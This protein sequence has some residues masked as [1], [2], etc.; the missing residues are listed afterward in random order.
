MKTIRFLTLLAAVIAVVLVL[1]LNSCSKK[2]DNGPLIITS[3]ATEITATSAKVGGVVNKFSF[4]RSVYYGTTSSCSNLGGEAP[5]GNGAFEITLTGLTPATKYYF[6]A[7]TSVSTNGNSQR[8]YGE[9]KSFTT[10]ARG[11]D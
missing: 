7:S 8:V 6:K 4:T 9:T 2:E 5:W 11:G 3:D 1:T 10:L